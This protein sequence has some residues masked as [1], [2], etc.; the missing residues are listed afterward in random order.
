[1][2]TGQPKAF[3]ALWNAITSHS[4]QSEYEKW[5]S[6]E[7]VPE[8]VGLP[9]FIQAKRYRSVNQ[10]LRYFT[11]YD[12]R[13]L[14]ALSTQEYRDVFT[15]PTPWSARMRK[16]LTDF[17][18]LPCQVGS[19]YGIGSATQLATLQWRSTTADLAEKIN[20]Q[21]HEMVSNGRAICAE[22]GFA[23][24]TEEYWL[25]N[26][27]S[28]LKGDGIEH[29][30]LLQHLDADDLKN[31]ALSFVDFLGHHASSLGQ[32]EYFEQLTHVRQD[33]IGD[34]LGT[35]RSP[36]TTLFNKSIGDHGHELSAKT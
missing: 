13:C 34:S 22:W 24:P 36:H 32:P 21:L 2:S 20:H 6:F 18:R 31:S 1:M 30:L 4:V 16:V 3:L 11:L 8:R 5:H 28:D 10:P 23:P 19:V 17:Y 12:L 15:N 33:E 14:D 35:R 27:S 7:H 25:P 9:G 26:A 29:V